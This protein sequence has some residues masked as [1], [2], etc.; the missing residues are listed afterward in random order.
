M[1]E[2]EISVREAVLQAAHAKDK[3]GAPNWTQLGRVGDQLGV[4]VPRDYVLVQLSSFLLANVSES[5]L[6]GVDRTT[7]LVDVPVSLGPMTYSRSN[8]SPSCMILNRR[9]HFFLEILSIDLP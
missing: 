8:Q 3:V 5:M 4:Q 1:V 2:V 9:P 7:V 6:L